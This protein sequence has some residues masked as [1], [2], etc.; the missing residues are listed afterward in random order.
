MSLLLNSSTAETFWN[1]DPRSIPDCA[2]WLDA[3]DTNTISLSGTTVLSWDSKGYIPISAIKNTGNVTYSSANTV[4]GINAIQCPSGTDLA[5][6]FGLTGTGGKSYFGVG[7]TETVANFSSDAITFLGSELTVR[8][9]AS[10]I[11]HSV[12]VRGGSIVDASWL[13]PLRYATVYCGIAGSTTALS[14][15]TVNGQTSSALTTNT[16]ATGALSTA[17]RTISAAVNAITTT[18]CEIIAYD[19]DVTPTERIAIEGYLMWKWGAASYVPPSFIPT[20][21][22]NCQLWLHSDVDI[23]N[24]S[25][26]FTFSSGVNISTWKDLSGNGRDATLIGGTTAPTLVEETDASA[27]SVGR[28]NV[29]AFAGN[30]SLLSSLDVPST[31]AVTVFVVGRPQSSSTLFAFIGLN[32]YGGTRGN[33]LIVYQHTTGYWFFS[34]GTAGTNGNT[35]TINT[36]NNRYDIVTCYWSPTIRTQVNAMGAYATPSNS[37]PTSL[38]SGTTTIG[39]ATNSGANTTPAEFLSG[40]IAEIIVYYGTLTQSQQYQVERYLMNKWNRPLQHTVGLTHPAR[41]VQPFSRRFNPVDVDN[42]AAWFDMADGTRLSGSGPITITDK[43]TRA[44]TITPQSSTLNQTGTLGNSLSTV[45]I[46]SDQSVNSSTVNLGFGGNTPSTVVLVGTTATGVM[47]TLR[48]TRNGS[49]RINMTNTTVEA[50]NDLIGNNISGT[51]GARTKMAIASHP[52]GASAGS[53]RLFE[54]GTLYGTSA[55]YTLNQVDSRFRVGGGAATSQFGESIY[56]SKELTSNERQCIE[57]YLAEK[58][59]LRASLSVNHPS[60]YGSA[61][62]T[63]RDFT[64]TSIAGCRVWLDATDISTVNSGSITAGGTVTSWTDK[65][66]NGTTFTVAGTPTWNY[67]LN[68]RASIDMTNGRMNATLPSAI[69][70]FTSTTFIVTSL[71]TAPTSGNPC[72]VFSD[73]STTNRHNAL[74]FTSPGVNF[75]ATI[76]PASTYVATMTGTLA[77]PFI[78]AVTYNG[79]TGS[80]ALNINR[81]AGATTATGTVSVALTTNATTMFIGRTAASST[82]NTW[83]G[84]ISEIITYNSV[85]SAANI[86]LVARYLAEKYSLVP[87]LLAANQFRVPLSL[88]NVPLFTPLYISGCTLWLDGLD[89]S[90]V[91]QSSGAV[92]LWMDKSGTRRHAYQATAGSRP[93]YSDNGIVFSGSTFLNLTNAFSM[94]ATT[95]TLYSIFIVERRTSDKSGNLILGFSGSNNNGIAMGYNTNTVFRLTSAQ[96]VDTDFTI[97]GFQN[98]DPV[99]IW[100]GI[101]NATNRILYLNGAVATTTAYTTAVASWLTPTIGWFSGFSLSNFYVGNV[102]EILVYNT[103]LTTLQR[104]SVEGYLAWKWN[105]RSTLANTHPYKNIMP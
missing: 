9:E 79:S 97:T 60:Y 50:L 88:P 105:L 44:D 25:T 12:R 77:T 8:R 18:I 104:Q 73:G 87:Q 84:V 96:T 65:S 67:S 7:K 16:L 78:W 45:L 100:A 13:P 102:Y 4:N 39:S 99:R 74:D 28:K 80:S 17:T 15:S 21:I 95:T 41:Y 72:V 46:P 76:V 49:I 94:L 11:N 62:T 6:S 1:F 61:Y 51:V 83:T 54:C 30:A 5:I 64:P 33:Q 86:I 91:S 42:L 35:I 75:R 14:T 47:T 23:S 10:G 101:Y 82:T 37:A 40:R 24:A 20:S 55:T 38:V 63:I 92:Q 29:V 98:P 27:L 3:A 26:N 90:T 2:I 68:G 19:R 66:G 69:T 59:D 36:Q 81:N 85:L 32:S 34:G 43:S 93:T 71:L 48:S 103:A 22:P 56:F 70:T 52:G 53:L 89:S 57:G 31:Q 58:W